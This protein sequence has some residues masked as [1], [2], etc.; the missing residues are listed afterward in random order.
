MKNLKL[1]LGI[2]FTNREYEDMDLF[3]DGF[4]NYDE[5]WTNITPQDRTNPDTVSENLIKV[6]TSLTYKW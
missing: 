6:Q 5:L 1:D 2:E 4:Y 3:M